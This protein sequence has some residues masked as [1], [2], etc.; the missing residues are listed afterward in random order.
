MIPGG[1]FHYLCNDSARCGYYHPEHT[2][3]VGD[4][5]GAD[6]LY[7]YIQQP[8][9]CN[10]TRYCRKG[11]F[12]AA[13]SLIPGATVGRRLITLDGESQPMTITVFE[14]AALQLVDT[15]VTAPE[16]AVQGFSILFTS[17]LE[18]NAANLRCV[19]ASAPHN[20]TL[21][22]ADP[23]VTDCGDADD[24]T[25]CCTG[26]YLGDVDWFSMPTHSLQGLPLNRTHDAFT[27]Y[28]EHVAQQ[29]R[30][31]DA[32]VTVI[33]NNVA[34]APIFSWTDNSLPFTTTTPRTILW[35]S[36]ADALYQEARA[37]CDADNPIYVAAL[38]NLEVY[39]PDL[40]TVWYFV[41]F[42]TDDVQNHFRMSL[43]ATSVA[44]PCQTCLGSTF[45]K[46][47]DLS[48]A[49]RAGRSY[50]QWDAQRDAAWSTLS[51]D[52]AGANLPYSL[53]G[54]ASEQLC[55][56]FG[57]DGLRCDS[58]NGAYCRNDCL[59]TDIYRR[60][61]T[62]QS[63]PTTGSGLLVPPH[64]LLDTLHSFEVCVSES[65]TG[66]TD[67]SADLHTVWTIQALMPTTDSAPTPAEASFT[68]ITRRDEDLLQPPSMPPSPPLARYDETIVLADGSCAIIGTYNNEPG[69]RLPYMPV[70]N[71][72]ELD[73]ATYGAQ[74][75]SESYLC[76]CCYSGGPIQSFFAT[77]DSSGFGI[78]SYVLFGILGFVAF[79]CCLFILALYCG[80]TYL[81]NQLR[82]KPTAR[83]QDEIRDATRANEEKIAQLQTTIRKLGQRFGVQGGETAS[84]AEGERLLHVL[85]V[86]KDME[87]RRTQGS[88]GA[89]GVCGYYA[90]GR[91]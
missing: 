52:E 6:Q 24:T 25:W 35:E 45:P 40:G 27:F 69:S 3:Y 86:G 22:L 48:D 36:Q 2:V 61:G 13:A 32:T 89:G 65:N 18:E 74:Q 49:Y 47:M 67:G 76:W 71:A 78:L 17:L 10:E 84:P 37:S 11:T 34:D 81:R 31:F 44:P 30:S 4:Y 88:T 66:S 54:N 62:R 64:K 38:S 20:G 73:T 79:L 57:D 23:S 60:S 83:K 26:Q 9:V 39:D 42:S 75:V 51:P 53:F 63:Q 46:N 5:V 28:I 70:V 85:R 55:V 50:A 1:I 77:G 87:R 15:T 8:S 14:E 29:M 56:P 68:L 12:T 43:N 41:R 72:F 21:Q 80:F 16:E 59:A 19:I 7:Y 58:A 91:L 82:R 90:L 33:V